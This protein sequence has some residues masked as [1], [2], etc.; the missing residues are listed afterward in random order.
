MDIKAYIESGILE[1]FALDQLGHAERMEVQQL[2]QQYPVLKDE[3]SQIETALERYAQKHAIIPSQRLQEKLAFTISN[4]QKEAAM[5]PLN[6]PLLSK[7]ADYKKWKQLVDSFG[8][9]PIGDDGRHVRI[10]RHDDEV[11]QLLIVSTTAFEEEVH[12]NVYE[13]FLILSGACRCTIGGEVTLM[14]AGDFMQ[15]PLLQPHEVQLISPK[16][17]AILQRQRV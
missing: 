15:I 9:L 17:T 1:L 16:V 14:S 2:L 5:D 13:S 7:A 6:L 8:P 4:L 11:T 12:E 10:L 3:L